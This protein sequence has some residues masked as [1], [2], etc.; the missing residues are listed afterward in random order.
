MQVGFGDQT[1]A[2]YGTQTRNNGLVIAATTGAAVTSVAKGRISYAEEFLT[3][4]NLVIIDHGSGTFSL[5]GN[6]QD[7]AVAVGEA[8]DTGA[9]L[10]HANSTV[11]FEL[12]KSNGPVDPLGYLR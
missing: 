2:A 8:V 3:Y 9:L 11:Y 12:R 1:N 5:Y 6:L 10:G 7:I 4:G